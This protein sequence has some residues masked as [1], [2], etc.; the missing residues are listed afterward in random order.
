MLRFHGI[1]TVWRASPLV[2]IGRVPGMRNPHRARPQ[3]LGRL[4]PFP[5]TARV[6]TTF[7]CGW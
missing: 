2:G 6:G 4:G 7:G 5:E 1:D 3:Y